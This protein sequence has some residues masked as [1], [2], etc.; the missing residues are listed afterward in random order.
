MEV[1]RMGKK[2]VTTPFA[3]WVLTFGKTALAKHLGVH[4]TAPTHWITHRNLP[5]A[6]LFPEIVKLSKGK[7]TYRII[8]D[9]F[10]R[11]NSRKVQK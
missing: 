9:E 2:K 11:M 8:I 5:N 4:R 10:L 6:E 3:D 1:S 7:L